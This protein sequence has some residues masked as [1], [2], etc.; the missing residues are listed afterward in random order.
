MRCA[1]AICL[2][3][4]GGASVSADDPKVVLKETYWQVVAGAGWVDF[5]ADRNPVFH[6]ETG[7]S[8]AK[9]GKF[10]PYRPDGPRTPAYFDR[11]GRVW[12]KDH[13]KPLTHVSDGTEWKA[14]DH[15]AIAVF[16]SSDG[17]TFV[18]DGK[19]VRVLDRNGKWSAQAICAVPHLE[20]AHF[21]ESGKRVWLWGSRELPGGSAGMLGAWSFTDGKWT[22]HDT[23]TG[24]PFDSVHWMHPL[25]DGRFVLL[26]D[27][28]PRGKGSAPAFWH[29]DRKLADAEKVVLPKP[30][31]SVLSNPET[32]TDGTLYVPG[33]QGWSS[34]WITV[35]A[36]GE[37]G[38]VLKSDRDPRQMVTTT[39][40]DRHTVFVALGAQPPALPTGEGKFIG[41]DRDG[42]YYFWHGEWRGAY[43]KAAAVVAVWPARE[44]PG[45]V[46]RLAKEKR[47]VWGV[48]KDEVGKIWAEPAYGGALLQ[49]HSGKWLD[50]PVGALYHPRWTARHASPWNEWTWSASHLFR[51]HGKNGSVVVVRVRDIHQ[52][53]EPQGEAEFA[54]PRPIRD[55][56]F[57][58]P[59]PPP[60]VAVGGQPPKYWLEAFLFHDGKWTG[61][62][63]IKKLLTDHASAL[64]ADFPITSGDASFFALANDGTRLWAAFDGRVLTT[65]KAG[66]VVESDWPREK[67]KRPIPFVM[68]GK[69]AD[70]KV[71]LAGGGATGD[72]HTLTLA[73]GKIAWE[74]FKMPETPLHIGSALARAQWKL[75]KDGTL[76][77][78][79][80]DWYGYGPRV[81]HFRN[82]KWTEK[83]GVGTPLFDD[84]DG[85]VVCVPEPRY[86]W[87]YDL[88]VVNGTETK[89][90][91]FPRE[92]LQLGI[93]A[94][95]KGARMWA[96]GERMFFLDASGAK[97]VLRSR[98]LTEPVHGFV[99][100]VVDAKGNVLLGAFRGQWE[101]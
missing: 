78:W 74:A 64:L 5:D 92:E 86:A 57:P 28:P 46:L 89:E 95:P 71:L 68:L 26:E 60:D 77:L 79:T 101:P 21:V 36:K 73:D 33:G 24:L 35:N 6:L 62:L 91:K 53:D 50:T 69:L 20:G 47:V 13:A 97:P 41:A 23:K 39:L 81:W 38:H 32:G 48:V 19:N 70:G 49:W 45:E 88:L 93:T 14:L 65:D 8:F 67:P 7:Y 43:S 83:K 94:V 59:A 34:T 72:G 98:I 4:V 31:M 82:D 80:S 2:L 66:K 76:W 85:N 54:P 56:K 58:H 44:K 51:L 30:E 25:A 100:V 15:A 90:L 40:P 22:H 1:L 55:P 11:A 63:G 17:H 99:S 96:L 61:P 37:V 10:V 9:T 29:P 42:R 27:Q 75:A 52:L 3:L 84:A 87:K 12:V 18:F 16:D